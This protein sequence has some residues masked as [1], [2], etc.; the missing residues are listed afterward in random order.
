MVIF[1]EKVAF[2]ENMSDN[3]SDV[4]SKMTYNISKMGNLAYI[5][6]CSMGRLYSLAFKRQ[7]SIS[8]GRVAWYIIYNSLSTSVPGTMPSLVK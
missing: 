2:L 5:L 8:L 7:L 6:S 4:E 3:L 1:L